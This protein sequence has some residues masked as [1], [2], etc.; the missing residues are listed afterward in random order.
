M[1]LS[2]VFSAYKP[3]KGRL[4]RRMCPLFFAFAALAGF[5]FP[6]SA[7]SSKRPLSRSIRLNNGVAGRTVCLPRIE[8]SPPLLRAG[9]EV[10]L[11]LPPG[12]S[13]DQVLEAV[14]EIHSELEGR[15]IRSGSAVVDPRRL[16]S[17]A[18]LRYDY[19]TFLGEKPSPSH[20]FHWLAG[21]LRRGADTTVSKEVVHWTWPREVRLRMRG[22]PTHALVLED[23]AACRVL[24][25]IEENG[26]L[27]QNAASWNRLMAEDKM[28]LLPRDTVCRLTGAAEG[29]HAEVEFLDG[30]WRGRKAWTPHVD[31]SSL[32]P[33]GEGE[34]APEDGPPLELIGWEWRRSG[35]RIKVDGAV[36]NLT[37][38]TLSGVKARVTWFDGNGKA[39]GTKSCALARQTLR[40]GETASFSGT[41]PVHSRME[42]AA[43]AFLDEEGQA[44]PHRL[45]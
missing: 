45:K 23:L 1:T 8:G 13:S 7:A 38:R 28:R 18:Y 10:R 35:E 34:T 11:L 2:L 27:P 4:L 17:G 37:R 31:W 30:K 41:A 22:D 16:P 29:R 24:D 42:S 6:A 15:P 9:Y 3:T 32:Q 26:K 5:F 44:V 14:K 33:A 25:R 21:G 43:I 39:I 20:S 19:R 40:P 36:K 12:L